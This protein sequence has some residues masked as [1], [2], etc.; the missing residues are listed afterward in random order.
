[1]RKDSKMM[2]WDAK[3]ATATAMLVLA[4]CTTSPLDK[5]RFQ[6]GPTIETH[7]VRIVAVDGAAVNETSSAMAPGLRKVTVLMPTAA[8]FKPGETKTIDLDVKAC[9]QY[10]LVATRDT[11]TAATDY[12][13]KV[14]Q[15]KRDYRCARAPG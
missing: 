13:V 8:G 10:W 7:P 12:D 14:D 15:E 9:T 1:M 5:A 4:G 6:Q 3:V 11:R 2:R